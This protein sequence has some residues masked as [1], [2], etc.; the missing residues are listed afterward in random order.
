MVGNFHT[1]LSA[2]DRSS[3]QKINKEGEDQDGRVEDSELIFPHEHIKNTSTSGVVLTE[4][5]LKASR[6]TLTQPRL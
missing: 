5:K 2:M 4:N 6:K 1:L 3:R